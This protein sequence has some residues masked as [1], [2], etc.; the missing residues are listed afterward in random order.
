LDD[1]DVP[2]Y[3]EFKIDYGVA[4]AIPK[5]KVSKKTPKAS[6]KTELVAEMS[7]DKK[8]LCNELY[9]DM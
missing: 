2:E 3:A 7:E 6:V 8:E 4:P 9:G 1:P 5:R